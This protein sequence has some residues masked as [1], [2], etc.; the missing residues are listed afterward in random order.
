METQ[1]RARTFNAPTD[2]AGFAYFGVDL[3][4]GRN[5]ERKLKN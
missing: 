3:K 5:F 4:L 2:R 1:R